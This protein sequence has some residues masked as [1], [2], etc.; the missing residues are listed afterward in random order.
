M[1]QSGDWSFFR[2]DYLAD[3]LGSTMVVVDANGDVEN[4][5]T[6]DAYGEPTVTGSLANEFDFAGQQ[7][8]P[9]A[10]QYLRAR[11][12]DPATGVFL[13]RDPLAQ[14][15]SWLGSPFGNAY[16]DPVGLNDPT[17]L[18][19]PVDDLRRRLH[20]CNLGVIG[21]EACEQAGRVK[22]AGEGVGNA[23]NRAVEGATGPV[24]MVQD[25]VAF[26]VVVGS[27]SLLGE[28]AHYRIKACA[29][30]VE[31]RSILDNLNQFRTLNAAEL[32]L[33]ARGFRGASILLS[34][35]SGVWQAY[36]RAFDSSQ[37][38]WTALRGKVEYQERARIESGIWSGTWD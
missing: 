4:G 25:I 33:A 38:P 10:L 18:D 6:Y 27:M 32:A 29:L 5:Y 36:K 34:I 9:T 31:C 21:R 28:Y 37:Q 24:R 19:S 8:D 7:T 2:K 3:G 15:P 26:A 12:Y 17:G 14:L 30:S 13:S 35:A 23:V 11:Y 1:K 16:A 22:E 20:P